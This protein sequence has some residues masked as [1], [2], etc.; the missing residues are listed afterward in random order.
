MHNNGPAEKPKK[1]KKNQTL[2]SLETKSLKMIKLVMN[3][4]GRSYNAIDFQF[5][6]GPERNIEKQT[7]IM[8]VG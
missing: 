5:T 1:N 6:N 4:V 8:D 3:W 7:A 2:S